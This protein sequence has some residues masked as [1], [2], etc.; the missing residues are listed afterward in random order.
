MRRRKMRRMNRKARPEIKR[1]DPKFFLDGHH[2]RW[3]EDEEEAGQEMNRKRT[4]V[5]LE[6]I[7]DI[8]IIDRNVNASIVPPIDVY[9]MRDSKHHV[10]SVSKLASV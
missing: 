8:T 9:V 5:S 6:L 7:Y 2:D 3:K 1:K 10:Q 4:Q